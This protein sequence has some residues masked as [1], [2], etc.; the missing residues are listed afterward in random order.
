M[1]GCI[2]A[3]FISFFIIKFPRTSHAKWAENSFPFNKH[4]LSTWQDF[5]NIQRK[6]PSIRTTVLCFRGE[7]VRVTPMMR[8][9]SGIYVAWR[10][11]L[12][13]SGRSREVPR[14]LLSSFSSWSTQPRGLGRGREMGTGLEWTVSEGTDLLRVAQQNRFLEAC[15]SF[16]PPSRSERS[17]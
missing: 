17:M 14:L 9:L 13:A 10:E 6:T 2:H 8:S 11:L 4:L 5:D 3:N 15:Q 7:E 16:F 12:L 1:N